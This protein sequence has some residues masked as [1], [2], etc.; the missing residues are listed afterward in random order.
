MKELR[1]QVTEELHRQLKQTALDENLTLKRLTTN[2]LEEYI[3][4]RQEK[5]SPR[6]GGSEP[7][8]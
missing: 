6:Q 4:R 7:A 8:R 2:A 5:K 1:L 3:R